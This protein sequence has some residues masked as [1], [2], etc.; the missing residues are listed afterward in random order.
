MATIGERGKAL[1]NKENNEIISFKNDIGMYVKSKV[2]SYLICAINSEN[3]TSLWYT[4]F[5]FD[6][7]DKIKYEESDINKNW[8]TRIVQISENN[9]STSSGDN[10]IKI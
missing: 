3:S 4:N 10:T 5:N 2:N 7:L 8:I 6:F 9:I 1:I